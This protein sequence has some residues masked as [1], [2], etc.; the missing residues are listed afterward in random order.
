MREVYLVVL[1][2]VASFPGSF[3]CKIRLPKG[4]HHTN[5]RMNDKNIVERACISIPYLR[6]LFGE[7]L[8]NSPGVEDIVRMHMRIA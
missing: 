1:R 5:R 2:N 4:Y 3:N 6:S 8:W 7:P